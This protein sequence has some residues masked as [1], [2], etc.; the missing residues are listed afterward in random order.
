[1]VPKREHLWQILP[2]FTSWDE[3]L[4]VSFYITISAHEIFVPE[5][6]TYIAQQI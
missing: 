4:S 5:H 3:G 6:L 1:M 2:V